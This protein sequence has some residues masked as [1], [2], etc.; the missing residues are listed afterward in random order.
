MG[1]QKFNTGKE[2][3]GGYLF[4]CV[5]AKTNELVELEIETV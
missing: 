2:S 4:N 5:L 1:V 3:Q